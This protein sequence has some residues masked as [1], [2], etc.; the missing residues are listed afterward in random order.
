MMSHI[1][2]VDFHILATTNQMQAM[3]YA[4][5]YIDKTLAKQ[6]GVYL[7]TETKAD[8][9]RLDTLLWTFR[10]DSFLPHTLYQPEQTEISPI[11]IGYRGNTL[12]TG[13]TML[14]LSQHLP[15]NYA[16]YSQIIEIVTADP[17]MQQLARER[18]KHY[19]DQ[20]HHINT[21]KM[22]TYD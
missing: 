19:R 9:E 14:N 11:Q 7:H 2:N 4:C 6:T 17:I 3:H 16:K 13:K 15:E 10:E 8:A 12:P 18:F 1:L 5:Q 21:H 20:G 22:K